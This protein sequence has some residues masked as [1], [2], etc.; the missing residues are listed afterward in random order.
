MDGTVTLYSVTA[1]NVP[2]G[3]ID[4]YSIA[5]DQIEWEMSKAELETGIFIESQSVFRS[6]EA[7]APAPRLPDEVYTAVIAFITSPDQI[8]ISA[9]IQQSLPDLDAALVAVF[10]YAGAHRLLLK[11]CVYEESK[12]C[13]DAGQIMRRNNSRVRIALEFVRQQSVGIIPIINR[14]KTQLT[15]TSHFDFSVTSDENLAVIRATLGHIL[16]AILDIVSVLP[17]SVRFVCRC[18][19]DA[20]SYFHRERSLG[21]RGVFMFFVFRILFPL[22]TQPQ[23]TDPPELVVDPLEMAKYPKLLTNIFVAERQLEP[24]LAPLAAEQRPRIEAFYENLTKCP[25]ASDLVPQPTYAAAT[26]A[27]DT[28]RVKC[29]PL[30]RELAFA[31]PRELAVLSAWLSTVA[32]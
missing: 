3:Q 14:L 15:Q 17:S 12:A 10:T 1:P 25:E 18:V 4:L 28:I 9:V 16:D 2:I 32:Q 19:D 26:A 20:V 6:L 29:A 8:F 31:P 5:A 7:S 27:V 13:N 30:A 23:D 22:I 24:H 21:R 11:H